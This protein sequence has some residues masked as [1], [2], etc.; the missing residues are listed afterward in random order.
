[1]KKLS[2][3]VFFVNNMLSSAQQLT[4]HMDEAF[5]AARTI[6]NPPEDAPREQ[7][8]LAHTKALSASRDAINAV[9]RN[10]HAFENSNRN[11]ETAYLHVFEGLNH[12]YQNSINLMANLHNL[13]IEYG[14]G[15]GLPKED[16]RLALSAPE[17]WSPVSVTTPAVDIKQMRDL[18]PK[19][20]ETNFITEL[21]PGLAETLDL[22][23]KN[24]LETLEQEIIVPNTARLKPHNISAQKLHSTKY[25]AGVKSNVLGMTLLG[26]RMA[27]IKTDP[28]RQAG[29]RAGYYPPCFRG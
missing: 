23:L 4:E 9:R 20:M 16:L 6:V 12:F 28:E 14:T 10:F 15:N 24:I 22:H 13:V 27:G 11:D 29:A 25:K 19:A 5:T 2:Q 17:T 7:L 3:E 8:D 18:A 1:M 21:F 26:D